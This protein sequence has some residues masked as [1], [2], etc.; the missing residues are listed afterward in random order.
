MRTFAT[1]LTFML[2]LSLP[3]ST[4]S[5]TIWLT[6]MSYQTTLDPSVVYDS[7]AGLY[8][9]WYATYGGGGVGYAVS[10]DGVQWFGCDTLVMKA[11][12]P[13]TYDRYIHSVNVARHRN[14]YLMLYTCSRAQD[15]LVIGEA[16]SED[17]MVWVK[18]GSAPVMRPILYTGGWESR[19]VSSGD[20]MT[21]GDT[22]YLWYGGGDGTHMSTGL[23]RSID[24]T[25]WVRDPRNPVIQPGRSQGFDDREAAVVGVT[26]KGGTFYMLYRG[27]NASSSHAYLLATS[28]NGVSWWQYP[29]GPVIKSGGVLGG[30]TVMWRDGVFRAWYCASSGWYLTMAISVPVTLDAPLYATG[31]P[32]G[33]VLHQNYPNPFNPS[34]EVR[35]DVPERGHVY[36]AI[37]DALGR[38]V[39]VIADE[40]R[41]AGPATYTWHAGQRASGMYV[42][43]MT[44]GGRT[45]ATKMTL[46]R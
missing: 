15:T 19:H 1:S 8:R 9:M 38:L 20:V 17:G 12:L 16:T 29:L 39:D 40:V 33:A 24:D 7:T 27:I 10:F 41:E 14:K 43:R 31:L 4:R 11:G 37:Y 3:C 2:L 42:C 5:Q 30:G 36:L 18:Y 13:G 32:S 28:L 21:V 45:I 46:V 34:T 23:A 25:T 44:F 35:V 26:R 6:T 22:V